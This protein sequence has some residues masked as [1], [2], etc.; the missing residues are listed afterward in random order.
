MIDF[1]DYVEPSVAPFFAAKHDGSWKV[2]VV[3]DIIRVFER[4][5]PPDTTKLP[6][7]VAWQGLRT[8]VGSILNIAQIDIEHAFYQ[9]ASPPDL[10]KLMVLLSLRRAY[11]VA[12]CP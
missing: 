3:L 11:F 7:P 10:S 12:N 1:A 2:R 5:N 8:T 9:I 6:T 4:L